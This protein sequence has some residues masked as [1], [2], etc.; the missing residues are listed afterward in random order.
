MKYHGRLPTRVSVELDVRTTVLREILDTKGHLIKRFCVED[1]FKKRV[2]VHTNSINKIRI[3]VLL[4]NCL[5]DVV[6]ENL[7]LS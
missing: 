1:F 2:R 6:S 5:L 4:S 3:A 7:S